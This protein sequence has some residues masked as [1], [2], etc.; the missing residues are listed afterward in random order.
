M[1][2][3][4]SK[5]TW[6]VIVS[7][8]LIFGFAN[9]YFKDPLF[10]NES[11]AEDSSLN[12]DAIAE[13]RFVDGCYEDKCASLE[14]EYKRQCE[15][16]RLKCADQ[17]MFDFQKC[18][19]DVKNYCNSS[20]IENCSLTCQ[21]LWETEK[22]NRIARRT[23]T[24]TVTG[25]VLQR[26]E[27]NLAITPNKQITPPTINYYA[28][29]EYTLEFS[30]Y[31]EHA[32]S[33]WRTI[34]FFSGPESSYRVPAIWL[35]PGNVAKLHL[36]H[37]S[38][39]FPLG[40]AC[41][42]SDGDIRFNEWNHIVFI[43]SKTGMKVY[44]NGVAS[45]HEQLRFGDVFVWGNLVNRQFYLRHPLSSEVHYGATLIRQIVW[46]TKALSHEEALQIYA[47]KNES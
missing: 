23:L 10:L 3:T 14:L 47:L 15:Q 24:R 1:S 25:T 30:L 17:H 40:V 21:Q 31:V 29:P 41:N 33:T 46:Y 32:S 39:S 4:K 22:Q 13:K 6:I 35:H 36:R 37:S 9:L 8:I 12:I 7:V 34:L 28:G 44:V 43:V 18:K 11:F 42:T 38:Q 27:V 45:G 5:A 2:L 26:E 16:I 19:D 20:D